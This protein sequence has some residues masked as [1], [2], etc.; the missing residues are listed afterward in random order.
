MTLVHPVNRGI[1][2]ARA[3]DKQP[4]AID[5]RLVQLNEFFEPDYSDSLLVIDDEDSGGTTHRQTRPVLPAEHANGRLYFQLNAPRAYQ[6]ETTLPVVIPFGY[7]GWVVPRSSLARNGL[8]VFSGLYD[9][10][11]KGGIG[12]GLFN[13]GGPAKIQYGAR[14]G[15][16]VM[17]EA[18]TVYEYNGQYQTR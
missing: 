3:I 8:H 4:N 1:K 2:P 14:I 12:G 10:G 6:F 18:E 9:A 5:I 13:L 11:F 7:V 16:F 17:A 15:Q